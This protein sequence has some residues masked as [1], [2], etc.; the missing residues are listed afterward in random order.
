MRPNVGDRIKTTAPLMFGHSKPGELDPCS[1]PVGSQGT[2]TW[3]NDW[4]DWL[5]EQFSVDWD[6]GV[7]GPGMLLGNDP[8][9]VLGLTSS[10]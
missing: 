10:P 1:P 2:V 5:T 9:Q 3:V 6:E 4:K 7:D 8:Y